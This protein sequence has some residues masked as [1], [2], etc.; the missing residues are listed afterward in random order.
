MEELIRSKIKE[1]TFELN[2]EKSKLKEIEITKRLV[3]QKQKIEQ[4]YDLLSDYDFSNIIINDI[5]N[6][7]FARNVDDYI[8]KKFDMKKICS[9]ALTI[10]NIKDLKSIKTNPTS[11]K[12]TRLSK[13]IKNEIYV[14]IRE[15]SM[16]K[17]KIEILENYDKLKEIYEKKFNISGVYYTKEEALKIINE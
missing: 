4:A 12:E 16:S 6:N 3:M 17:T 14:K 7:R 9:V 5:I 15:C 11:E 13:N 10:K 2:K 8:F 1:L